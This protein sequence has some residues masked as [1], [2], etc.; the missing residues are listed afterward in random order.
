MSS[1]AVT[2]IQIWVAA[3]PSSYVFTDAE[4]QIG[5]EGTSRLAFMRSESRLNEFRHVDIGRFYAWTALSRP[6]TYQTLYLSM[7]AIHLVRSPL[8]STPSWA[9]L[10]PCN[11]FFVNIQLCTRTSIT[12]LKIC[13][14]ASWHL[15]DT[16]WAP[17]ATHLSW[18]ATRAGIYLSRNRSW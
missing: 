5:V 4:L 11:I 14:E 8:L 7:T 13:T 2:S 15:R 17:F 3:L 16:S 10:G 18:K 1:M 9:H 12:L 6:L